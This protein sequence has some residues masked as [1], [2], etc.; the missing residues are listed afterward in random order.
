MERTT[1]PHPLFVRARDH[2]EQAIAVLSHDP[3]AAR[4]LVLLDEAVDIAIELAHLQ[5]TDATI[6]RLKP[7]DEVRDKRDG[8]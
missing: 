8:N 5:Q 2:I 7:S 6:L 4:L 3:D 1:L